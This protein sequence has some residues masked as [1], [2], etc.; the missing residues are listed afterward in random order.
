MSNRLK[1]HVYLDALSDELCKCQE[2]VAVLDV[3]QASKTTCRRTWFHND[4]PY[5]AMRAITDRVFLTLAR[6]LDLDKRLQAV[7]VVSTCNY[8]RKHVE[9]FTWL[10]TAEGKKA[11][12]EG[13]TVVLELCEKWE[14][15]VINHPTR[16]K[17]Q[18]LRDK[19]IAHLDKNWVRGEYPIEVTFRPEIEDLLEGLSKFV[20]DF[21]QFV[22][23]GEIYHRARYERVFEDT[24]NTL[25]CSEAMRQLS[26]QNR[27]DHIWR[28]L[29]SPHKDAIKHAVESQAIVA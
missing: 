13:P 5:I 20:N 2:A 14:A 7:T 28:E 11:Y 12:K 23:F 17:I 10:F 24:S 8:A 22:S 25:A 15:F 3:L 9:E 27:Q 19:T 1:L 21:Q 18:T 6:M 4:F 16:G 26:E 29:V